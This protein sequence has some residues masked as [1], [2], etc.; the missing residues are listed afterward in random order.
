MSQM[1]YK[2]IVASQKANFQDTILYKSMCNHCIDFSRV[3][4]FGNNKR[5]LNECYNEGITE[6]IKNG[7][8]IAVF[9]HDDVII[10]CDD[11]VFRIQ[12][13]ASMFDVTGLAGNT[14][15]NIKEPVL[16]HLLSTREKLRGCVAPGDENKYMYT[17]Y[18]YIPDRVLMIDGVFMIVNLKKLPAHVRFDEQ[19]PSRFHFYDLVFSMECSLNRVTI[20]VGDV[21]IIHASP[22]LREMHNEWQ[23]GQA[24]FLQKYKKYVGKTLTV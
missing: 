12:K 10:N 5:S 9:V 6:C 23:Q 7:I 14:T 15:L 22:G 19:I 18:G 17:S 2:F 11:V 16:C 1:T 13:Y 4:F 21:P 20:G 3:I 24:Y 8:D